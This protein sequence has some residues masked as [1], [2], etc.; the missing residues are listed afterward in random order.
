MNRSMSPRIA[1]PITGVL[2][3]GLSIL[4]LAVLLIGPKG[5]VI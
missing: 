2:S 1:G 5:A 4:L 3:L